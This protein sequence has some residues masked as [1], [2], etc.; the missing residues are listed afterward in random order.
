MWF[1]PNL[2]PRIL[3]YYSMKSGSELIS[4]YRGKYADHIWNQSFTDEE[5][6]TKVEYEI[7]S[8]FDKVDL[9]VLNESS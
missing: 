3:N 2:N 8:I 6:K 4:Y 5:F 1:G 9:I 7:N